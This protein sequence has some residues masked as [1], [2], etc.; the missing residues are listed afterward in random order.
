[1]AKAPLSLLVNVRELPNLRVIHSYCLFR[2]EI[3]N[4]DKVISPAFRDLRLRLSG[5]GLDS[6]SLRHV[7]VPEVVDGHLV[8]YDYCIEFP[9]PDYASGI[10][11]FAGER[12]AV[13]TMEKNPRKIVSAIRAFRGDYLLDHGFILVKDVP[14]I[15]ITSAILW[16]SASLFG[17][18]HSGRCQSQPAA[19]PKEC[20]PGCPHSIFTPYGLSFARNGIKKPGGKY[21]ESLN[22]ARVLSEKVDPLS[23]MR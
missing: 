20:G 4:P 10:Q 8:S 21:L 7:G 3:G 5:F 19:K 2:S 12:Y 17:D 16:N 18:L 9:L 23:Y 13:L 22:I 11:I 15:S 14:F 6:D 1:M